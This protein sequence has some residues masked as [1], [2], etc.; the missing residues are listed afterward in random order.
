MAYPCVENMWSPYWPA[1]GL[2]RVESGLGLELV[3]SGRR[4]DVQAIFSQDSGGRASPLGGP[5]VLRAR[6]LVAELRGT[7]ESA[8]HVCVRNFF[9]LRRFQRSAEGEARGTDRLLGP[10]LRL[11]LLALEAPH[12]IPLERKEPVLPHH[13]Q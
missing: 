11:R 7:E 9:V 1:Q 6:H 8:G 2:K 5:E 10:N 4:F 13:C 3:F 12:G